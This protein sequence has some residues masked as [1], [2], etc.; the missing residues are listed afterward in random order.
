MSIIRDIYT[1]SLDKDTANGRP[2]TP[3]QVKSRRIEGNGIQQVFFSYQVIDENLPCRLLKGLHCSGEEAGN[4][5]MPYFDS[6]RQYQGGQNQIEDGIDNLS[7][8]KLSL[9]PIA[10]SNYASHNSKQEDR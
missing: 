3:A 8:N 4:I 7:N 9:T 6:A 2:H 10:V 1:K 5:D